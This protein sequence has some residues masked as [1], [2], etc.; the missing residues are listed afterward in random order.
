MSQF[1][2]QYFII[3]YF[4][5]KPPDLIL[6]LADHFAYKFYTHF[7]HV[8]NKLWISQS[9]KLICGQ[10]YH[11]PPRFPVII[12]P[13]INLDGMGKDARFINNIE[14]F[15]KVTNSNLFWVQKLNG[16]HYSVDIFL[17]SRGIQGIICFQGYPGFKFT[18]KYW[19]YLDSY[20]LPKNIINWISIHLKNYHGVFNLE[21]IENH[22]IECHLRIGDLIFFQ[23]HQL[24]QLVI[25]CHLDKDVILPKLPK[26]F[27]IPI[28]VPKGKFFTLTQE[29]IWTAIGQSNSSSS[30]K[31][32]K[33][34]YPSKLSNPPGGNRI[35]I[36][37]FD[38]LSKGQIFRKKIYS[39]LAKK[40]RIPL[41]QIKLV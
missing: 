23:N 35:C 26:I 16:N 19:K 20:Q 24:L 9:Q 36:C 6:P 15:H 3:K 7:N 29:D 32:F 10:L 12:R 18:F 21:I 8:Y 4:C 34:D 30:I 40:N 41:A 2:E 1:L 38:S 33:I 28:F 37:S 25:N 31:H 14:D 17:N 13:Q 11:Q 22:I 27:L 39:N 5:Q